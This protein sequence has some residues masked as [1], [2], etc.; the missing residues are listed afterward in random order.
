MPEMPEVE[1]VRRGLVPHLVGTTISFVDLRRPNLRFPFPDDF[2]KTLTGAKIERIDRRSKYLLFRLSND[3]T[4]MSHLGMTGVW[5]IGGDG[6]G[7]HDHVY[8]EFNDG[9]KTAIYTDPRRFGF[10]DTFPTSEESEQKWLS[11]LGPEPLT[12]DFTIEILNSN[13]QGKR[14]PIKSALLDQR[15]VSGLGN[16]YVSEI[17]FRCKISPLKTAGEIASKTQRASVKVQRIFEHTNQVI[18]EAIMVGGS[19]ISDFRGVSGDTDLGYF[20]QQFRVFN[21]EGEECV[22]DSCKEIILRIVQSGRSTFY[23]PKCQR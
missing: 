5:T 23:C 20:A 15:V 6:S 3:Q 8:F 1:T 10:M 9:A 4:W 18:A 16:I 13:L 11:N 17:L 22:N 7:K 14:S 2:E 12:E 21:R 19:T